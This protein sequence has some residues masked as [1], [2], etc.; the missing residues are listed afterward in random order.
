L[1]VEKLQGNIFLDKNKIHNY[2]KKDEFGS[3][4]K[5]LLEDQIKNWQQLADNYKSL[6]T[7]QVKSFQFD[8]FEIKVQFNPGRII[9]SSAKVDEKS[10]NER[11]C[12][13]CYDNFPNEQKGILY[14]NQ[15]LI[16]CNP[17]PIFPE[18]FT[19]PH[20]DHLP[21]SIKL[22]F[23]KLLNFSKDLAKY[24]TVFYNGPKCGASAPDHLHFQAGTKNFM[25]IE[26]D[27]F[28]IKNKFGDI[29][30]EDDDIV[31]TGVN[32]K[33]RR[34]VVFEGTNQKRI[35]HKF[36][37]FYDIYAALKKNNNEEPL[38]NIIA[39]FDRNTRWRIMVFL[40]DK[41]RPSHYFR[42]GEQQ[43]LLSP[44]A[45]DMGGICITPL[46]KDFNKITEDDIIDIFHEVSLS[47]EYFEYVKAKLRKE[48]KKL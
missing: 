10:I 37:I 13:L 42:Q 20:V 16:L 24:Y 47:R 9:S 45:V 4:A 27:F 28:P 18:H 30:F 35:R 23:D 21:Q 25:P 34:F 39:Y 44:A 8:E 12:F 33:L 46:E 32:D 22:S 31:V 41:H 38:M 17:F 3:A 15:Y 48:L 2:V 43:I 26:K 14:K 40:R 7:V 6:Q 5:V 11:K 19:L 36:E 1:K 29:L